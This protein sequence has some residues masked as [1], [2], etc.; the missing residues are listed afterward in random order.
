M[1]DWYCRYCFHSTTTSNSSYVLQ[2]GWQCPICK[3]IMAPG[4]AV[5]V[6]C[7]GKKEEKC[8]KSLALSNNKLE[9]GK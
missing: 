8:E 4:M 9:E 1:S 7:T 5:C 2:Q 6:N 3:A